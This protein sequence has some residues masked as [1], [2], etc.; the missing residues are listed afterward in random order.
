MTI[1]RLL[2]FI[3]IALLLAGTGGCTEKPGAEK[4]A[5]KRTSRDHLVEV[6]TTR[7]EQTR[8]SHERTGSLRARRTVRIHN[9]E[10]GRVTAVPFYEGDRVKQ[11]ESLVRLADDLLQAELEKAR[12]TTRQANVDLKRIRGLVKKRAASE[13][14][15]ARAQTAVDVARAEQKLLETRIGYTRITAPFAGVISERKIE[16]GDVVSKHSHLLTVTDPGS[17]VTEIHVSE[18]LLPHLKNGDPVSVRIDALGSGR[19]TGS[20]L[21]IHPELDSLTRQGVVE[22]LLEPVPDGARA[23]Q[24]ARV[25]LQ[26]AQAERLLVP[27]G[28]IRRDREGE[29]VFLMGQDQ[30][31]RQARIRSGIRLAEKIEVLEG[32]ESGQRVITRG[33]LGLTEG[34]KV[35]A[36]NLKEGVGAKSAQR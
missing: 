27:F 31:A 28:A 33:F 24:F 30:K 22:V 3:F 34:K 7:N 5:K 8:S 18:L 14:E 2:S 17:L 15:L 4:K 32:L 35:K 16:P 1:S 10:E 11:G 23:G 25:T 13:D 26:T 12:A 29:Y 20:I 36:V 21:R 6:I 19:F 9:Q